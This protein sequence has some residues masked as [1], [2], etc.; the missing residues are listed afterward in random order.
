MSVPV[1]MTVNGKEASAEPEN[2]PDQFNGRDRPSG[3]IKKLAW[4]G[5]DEKW[6]VAAEFLRSYQI[7][8]DS[9]NSLVKKVDSDGEEL[10]DVAIRWVDENEGVWRPWVKHAM[11]AAGT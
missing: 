5:I 7:T 3:W 4:H 10:E 1:S 6:P 9:Q 11:K 8:N 2:R